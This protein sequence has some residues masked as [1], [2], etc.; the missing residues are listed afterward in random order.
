LIK[1]VVFDL[2][3]T[4]VL[5]EQLKALSYAR[6]AAELVPAL[7]SKEDEIVQAFAELAGGSRREV[8]TQLIE[9]FRLEPSARAR[10]AEFGVGTPWQ[11]Y[12]QIRLRIYREIAG[13][14]EVI[15]RSQRP[16]VVALVGGMRRRGLRTALTSMSACPEVQRILRILELAEAFDF[17]ATGDEVE[18]G[19]PDP[20][21]YLVVCRELN[22]LP[23]QCLAIE[24]SL[25]G[26]QSALA[27]GAFCIAAPTSFTRES[28]RAAQV[29]DERW[30]V[31]EPDAL[32]ATVDRMLSE[33]EEDRDGAE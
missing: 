1:T 32:A 12:V 14:S 23:S 15:R 11:A 7:A 21:L 17:I 18:Q 4:L 26:V 5:T 25:A 19:K 2:D 24:D 16:E 3:G 6:A 10:M 20:E 13:D 29:L 30:I 8:A 9:R 31:E 28:V 33:R 27:A 22:L